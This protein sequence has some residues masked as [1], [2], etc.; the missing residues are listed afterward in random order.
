VGLR[1]VVKIMYLARDELALSKNVQPYVDLISLEDGNLMVG[2]NMES[3][4]QS[5]SPNSSDLCFEGHAH[6]SSSDS[7][8]TTSKYHKGLD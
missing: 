1:T 7:S 2:F 3:V 8:V 4:S 5:G 6:R